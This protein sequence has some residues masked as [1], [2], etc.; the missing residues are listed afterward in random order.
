LL[1]EGAYSIRF[2]KEVED[3]PIN[4]W[5]LMLT[6]NLEYMFSNKEKPAFLDVLVR[7][8]VP[9]DTTEKESLVVVKSE[10]IALL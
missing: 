2:V 3:Y 10:L 7:L 6:L 1:I 5:N 4:R 8:L 9:S